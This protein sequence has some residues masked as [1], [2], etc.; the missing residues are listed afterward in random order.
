MEKRHRRPLAVT[1]TVYGVLLL[2][3]GY[4]LQSGQAVTRYAL[5][6]DLPLSVP[7]WYLALS[8]AC[9]GAL[10]LALGWG[11]WRRKEW[12]RRAALFAALLQLAA[13]WADRILFSRSEIA[14][15]SFGFELVL[16]LL[17]V[18]WLTAVLLLAGRRTGET[19]RD[20]GN[21]TGEHTIS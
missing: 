7:A 18:G 12:A 20:T 15:Q 6:S 2:G 13:W 16:R 14:I 19:K 1:L 8:G 21:G 5:L 4:L 3:G 11:L 17:A 10:W 9:W